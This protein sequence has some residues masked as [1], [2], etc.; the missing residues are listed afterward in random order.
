MIITKKG[1]SLSMQTLFPFSRETKFLDVHHMNKIKSIWGRDSC[2]MWPRGK[3]PG[4]GG[5][6]SRLS[7]CYVSWTPRYH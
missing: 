2:G 1:P 4:R 5:G 3:F 7:V 6:G